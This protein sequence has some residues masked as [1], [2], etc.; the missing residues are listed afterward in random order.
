[1][2]LNKN[3]ANDKLQKENRR[4]LGELAQQPWNRECCDC[5]APSNISSSYSSSMYKC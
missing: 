5:T 2:M 3:S 4:K 1:M